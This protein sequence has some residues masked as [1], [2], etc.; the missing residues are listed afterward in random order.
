MSASQNDPTTE[1]VSN[2]S[3]AGVPAPGEARDAA[4][5]QRRPTPE[6]QRERG[7]RMTA[8]LEAEAEIVEDDEIDER[9]GTSGTQPGLPPD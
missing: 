1:R 7:Q 8:E 5:T 2:P 3:D 4:N 6:E 9:P